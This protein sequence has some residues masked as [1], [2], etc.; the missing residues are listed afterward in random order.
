[1]T[2]APEAIRAGEAFEQIGRLL[3]EANVIMTEGMTEAE[4]AMR[5]SNKAA[6]HIW[7]PE[8]AM[9]QRKTALGK[10]YAV[11]MRKQMRESLWSTFEA[12]AKAIDPSWKLPTHW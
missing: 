12:E 3:E 11:A 6:S 7:S 9:R 10:K 5:R 1:M 2:Q 8:L 4:A